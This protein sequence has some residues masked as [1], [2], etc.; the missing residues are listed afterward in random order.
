[1]ASKSS[2]SNKNN[3]DLSEFEKFFEDLQKE[4]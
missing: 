4:D 2:D 3:D 1:M